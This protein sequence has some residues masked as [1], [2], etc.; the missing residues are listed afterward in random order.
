MCMSLFCALARP[1]DVVLKYKDK[2]EAAYKVLFCDRCYWRSHPRC[3]QSECRAVE[4]KPT[5]QH[6]DK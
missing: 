5:V 2:C 3:P 1:D 4:G 6:I